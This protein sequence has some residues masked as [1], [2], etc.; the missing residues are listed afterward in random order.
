[1]KQIYL[2]TGP[3]GVGKTTVGKRLC[4]ALG[5]SAFIDG[6]W[7]LDIH[8][9][10]GNKETRAMA[11]DNIIH[12]IRNYVR[13][14]E[15]DSVVLSWIMSENTIRQIVDGISDGDVAAQIIT[16]ICSEG[17]LRE[18]WAGDTLTEWRNEHELKQ[19]LASLDDYVRRQTGIM[20]DT[21]GMGVDSVV[22]RIIEI[23][24]ITG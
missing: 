20:I 8:P 17:V 23:T 2:I 16:L 3:M 11:V 21:G 10:V 24:G 1:M 9:F 18:R 12:L 7:C 6:D 15:C 13:C 4:D 22:R 5:R 19:S 14:S